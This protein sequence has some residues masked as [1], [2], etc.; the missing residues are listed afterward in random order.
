MLGYDNVYIEKSLG[1]KTR[2]QIVEVG[3]RPVGQTKKIM[4]K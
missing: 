3:S 4:G 1:I 2:V